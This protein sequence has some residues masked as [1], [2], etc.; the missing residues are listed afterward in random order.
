MRSTQPHAVRM[1][2]TGYPAFESALEAIRQDVD[3]YLIKP[4]DTE[5]LVAKIKERLGRRKP[6]AQVERKRLAAVV[7]EHLA[8]ISSGWLTLVKEDAVFARV[9]VSNE[10]FKLLDVALEVAGGKVFSAEAENIAIQYGIQRKKQGVIS[11]MLIREIRLLHRVIAEYTQDHLLE[12]DISHLIPD[13]V[14]LHGTIDLLLE[15]SARG[16]S[17][18]AESA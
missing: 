15:C 10:I 12:V 17:A 2:L 5:Q 7:R 1:I 11:P 9:P 4:T 16:L 3:E 6:A 14:L 8:S 13:M 18:K